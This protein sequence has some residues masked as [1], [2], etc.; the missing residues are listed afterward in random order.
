MIT[1]LDAINSALALGDL[2]IPPEGTV[3]QWRD[4]KDKRH[5]TGKVLFGAIDSGCVM[6]GMEIR[7]GLVGHLNCAD[8]RGVQPMLT[9]MSVAKLPAGAPPFE[10]WVRPR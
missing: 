8:F 1:Q 4:S 9:S 6:L 5:Y 10:E 2:A 3:L 7:V